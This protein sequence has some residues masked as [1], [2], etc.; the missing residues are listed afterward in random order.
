MGIKDTFILII[1]KMARR[2]FILL[3]TFLFLIIG[4]VDAQ[5]TKAV[6]TIAITKSVFEKGLQHTD[7]DFY[8]GTLMMHGI[9]EFALLKGND[10]L[11]QRVVG[12]Y[13]KFGTGEIKAKGNFISYEAGGS[14]A[15]YLA[16]KN[17]TNKLDKQVSAAA[18]KMMKKQK[19]SPEGLMTAMSANN[20]L[21]QVFID[22]AFAVTPY[23]LYSGLKLNNQEYID[24]ATF[25]TLG[26]FKILRDEKTG[27]LH[28][29]RG[30][31][32]LGNLTEDNWSRGNGW[33]AFA[34][35][36]LV[37]DLPVNHPKRAEVEAL[38]KQFFTAVV[39]FYFIYGQ[40][41]FCKPFVL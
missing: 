40:R 31:N 9:S 27:L 30:Y 6:S 11:L 3:F 14:G 16:Y 17:A 7:I 28:Q 8:A 12:L 37:R 4:N 5:Y 29:A 39:K 15:A 24:F 36:I 10:E 19:R 22:M 25:E 35:A 38:A 1:D 2:T 34:L 21:H 32:G 20:E 41:W 26:L 23:L 33:G 18:D 13:E